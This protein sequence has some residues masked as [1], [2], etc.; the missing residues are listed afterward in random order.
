LIKKYVLERLLHAQK[1]NQLRV[2]SALLDDAL[3]VVFGLFNKI[4]DGLDAAKY[5]V[6]VFIFVNAQ[7]RLTWD[8]QP[9]L[10]DQT[11]DTKA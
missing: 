4:V 2:L 1:V 6:L 11:P 10:V 9:V 7:V 3:D 5:A 8:Q